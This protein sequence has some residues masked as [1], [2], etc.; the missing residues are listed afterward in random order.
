M[1]VDGFVF[2]DQAALQMNFVDGNGKH[3]QYSRKDLQYDLQHGYLTAVPPPSVPP[4]RQLHPV[5]LFSNCN[6]PS[7]TAAASHEAPSRCADSL[8]M[9]DAGV[10][11]TPPDIDDL[12]K[13]SSPSHPAAGHLWLPYCEGHAQGVSCPA[14]MARVSACVRYSVGRCVRY[15]VGRC[16]RCSVGHCVRC[17]VGRCVRYSVGPVVI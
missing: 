17:S 10:D 14:A 11:T 9:G 3:Q 13:L 1:G 8:A 15:S 12:N 16:V 4:D 5:D 6:Q 7:A 2:L